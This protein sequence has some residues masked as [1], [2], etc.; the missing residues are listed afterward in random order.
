MTIVVDASVALKW[1]LLEP[2]SDAAAKLRDEDLLAPSLWRL[3]VA[4]ALWKRAKRG[5]ITVPQAL[6]RMDALAQA[7]V[8]T[9]P[10]E[11]DLSVALA[12]AATLDH[13]VY[14]CLYLALAARNDTH[15]VTADVRFWRVAQANPAWSTRVRL[16]G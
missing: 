1:V 2:G 11:D 7:P 3:E 5:D 4:S 9:S 6:E 13:P 15:V 14:D 16:L 12:L 10:L 8:A